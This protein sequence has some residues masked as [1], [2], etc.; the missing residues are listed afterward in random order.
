M[1]ILLSRFTL[2]NIWQA[3]PLC[4]PHR[5]GSSQEAAT[6]NAAAEDVTLPP[7]F[8]V[9]RN[10]FLGDIRCSVIPTGFST[11]SPI[12]LVSKFACH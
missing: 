3:A 6:A 2:V 1:A 9:K 5:T 7:L 4:S 10:G 12:G 8:Y 11:S